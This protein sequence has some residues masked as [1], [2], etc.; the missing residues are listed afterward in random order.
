MSKPTLNY[1]IDLIIGAAFIA[2]AVS[3]VVFLLPFSADSVL[4]LSYAHWD[5]IHTWGSLL[6]IGGVLA[7]LALHWKWL[8]H[9]TRKTLLP[10]P[11]PARRA[12]AP[13]V[14]DASRRDFL[15]LTGRTAVVAGLA[16]A[17]YEL[18]KGVQNSSAAGE[19]T[20][21][22]GSTAAAAEPV[23]AA[24]PAATVTAT[25]A[26]S[27]SLAAAPAATATPVTIPLTP[28]A[29]PEPVV[30]ASQVTVACRKGQVNCPFPGRCH[31]YRD[32]NGNGYC[33]LSQPA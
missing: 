3:G 28:T 27:E 20:T 17:G 31:S 11:A 21:A 24:S 15:G 29:T 14:A 30:Q 1:W 22:E 18:L 25:P 23:T 12:G 26:A 16:I 13:V 19:S 6:M 10:A 33:D 32:T 7:H 5:T 2:S 9:M 4:G 8:T